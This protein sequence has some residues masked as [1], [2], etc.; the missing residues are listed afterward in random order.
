MRQET[1]YSFPVGWHE[2]ELRSICFAICV[3]RLFAFIRRE[4]EQE[5]KVSD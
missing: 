4:K 5:E 2:S 3:S 1:I